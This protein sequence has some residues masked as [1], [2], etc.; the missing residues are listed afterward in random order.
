MVYLLIFGLRLLIFYGQTTTMSNRLGGTLKAFARDAATVLGA[1]IAVSFIS[2][3]AIAGPDIG[4]PMSVETET[5]TTQKAAVATSSSVGSIDA[6]IE[7]AASQI[8]GVVAP[9]A[10]PVAAAFQPQPTQSLI[11]VTGPERDREINCLAQ[12]VYYEARG[13]PDRG[14][15]AVAE[16][17]VN[18]VNSRAYPNTYCGVVRQRRGNVCQ[19]SWVCT[20][21]APPGGPQWDRSREIA[22]R[23]IDGWKP[24]VVGNATHFHASRVRP[25]W[26]SVFPKVAQIGSHVFYNGR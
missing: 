19:F 24:G 3:Q 8:A 15:L 22:V 14:K 2:T 25:N 26:A 13:E 1:F 7:A 12:A 5:I 18:R 11:T 10:K 16:V 17:I 23:V 9:I 4:K 20:R 21:N 6:A